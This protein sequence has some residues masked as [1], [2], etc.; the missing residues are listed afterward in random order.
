[1]GKIFANETIDKG[2][3]S[4]IHKKFMKLNIKKANNPIKKWAENVNRHF[5][6]EGIQMAK[7]HMKRYSTSLI[8]RE[9]QIKTTVS[10]HLTLIKVA[11][12]KKSINTC[13]RMF[14]A[15]QFTIVK[16]WKQ[17]KCPLTDEWIKK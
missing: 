14:T 11:I 12:I 15:A 16:T 2:L 13:T 7:R 17:S 5:S 9:T 10:Y 8:I 1:M 6:K 4:K 3:I